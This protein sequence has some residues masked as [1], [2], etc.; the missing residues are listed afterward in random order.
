MALLD[1]FNAGQDKYSQLSTKVKLL[2]SELL[3]AN[4]LRVH[5]V[6]TRVKSEDSFRQKINR[7]PGK[8]QELSQVTD[9]CGLRII[10]YFEDEV[11]RVANIIEREFTIDRENSIDKRQT[12]DVDRFG[13]MSVHCV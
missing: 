11:E 3:E 6:T 4:Q 7:F 10:T 1:D 9:I 5:S 8:Y 12:M 13:Y 2:I